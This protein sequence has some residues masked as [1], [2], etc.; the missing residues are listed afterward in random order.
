MLVPFRVHWNVN[1]PVPVGVVLKV[2]GVPGQFVSETRAVAEAFSSTV[3]VAQLV[4]LVQN[5]ATRTQYPAASLDWT[6]A[7]E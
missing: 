4:T 6:A 2:A 1:G 5:P 3:S 7:I